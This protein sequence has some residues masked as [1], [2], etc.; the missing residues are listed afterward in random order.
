MLI[1]QIDYKDNVIINL[2]PEN[3][4]HTVQVA[5]NLFCVHV[6]YKNLKFIGSG[7]QGIVCSAFD[8][9][10]KQT[11]AIK[12]IKSPFTDV[13]DAKRAY[14][15]LKLLKHVNYKYIIKL[16]DAFIIS[17]DSNQLNLSPTI[18]QPSST[19]SST[20]QTNQNDQIDLYLIMEYV[21]MNLSQI[22][23]YK[24]DHERLSYLIYQMF[25]ALKYLNDSFIIH[26]DIK[27]SNIGIKKDCSIKILDFGSARTE[28]EYMMSTYVQ[29]R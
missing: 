4:F 1:E 24:F 7:S 25:C 11:V 13:E 29:T 19:E 15:E 2:I 21:E 28:N 27:P 22:I 6:R 8:R 17:A 14:R 20:N 5:G 10:F 9:I 16:L 3:E 18:N 12:K 23:C 26:R